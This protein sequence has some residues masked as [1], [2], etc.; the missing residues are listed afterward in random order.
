[1]QVGAFSILEAWSRQ[2]NDTRI[3]F[4]FVVENYAY[5]IIHA[6]SNKCI[7]YAHDRA[8][9]SFQKHSHLR[10]LYVICIIV[11]QLFAIHMYRASFQ[12]P[13]GPYHQMSGSDDAKDP[14]LRGGPT[15]NHWNSPIVHGG[16]IEL[17]Q[18]G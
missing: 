9:L 12:L 18:C 3:L 11:Y 8:C 4:F 5:Q 10:A 1:M 13:S 2:L 16:I 14:V 15:A 17:Y 6:S 7:V